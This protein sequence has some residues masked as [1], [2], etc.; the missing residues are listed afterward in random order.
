MAFAVVQYWAIDQSLWIEAANKARAKQQDQLQDVHE[1]LQKVKPAANETKKAARV[2]GKLFKRCKESKRN[3]L[4][5]IER[6][7]QHYRQWEEVMD[8]HRVA[9][10]QSPR[11]KTWLT[12]EQNKAKEV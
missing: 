9:W 11:P 12:K 3:P 8:Y 10:Y 6:R 7:R 4:L 2:V 5:R 1:Q